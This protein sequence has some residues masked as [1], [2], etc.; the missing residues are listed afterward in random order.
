MEV[1]KPD[2]NTSDYYKNKGNEFFRAHKYQQAIK[3]YNK[4]I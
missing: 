4:A 2:K 3:E 1:E